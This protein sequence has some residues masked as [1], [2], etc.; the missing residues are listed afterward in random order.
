MKKFLYWFF[1]ALGFICFAGGLLQ[2]FMYFAFPSS[3]ALFV[4]IGGILWGALSLYIAKKIKGGKK[5]K[6]TQLV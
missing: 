6:P 3:D 4:S 2:L 1:K 5:K